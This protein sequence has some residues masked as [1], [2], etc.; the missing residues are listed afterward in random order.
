[1]CGDWALAD[2]AD[3]GRPGPA[4]GRG[5]ARRRRRPGRLRVR[6]SDGRSSRR[7]RPPRTR[8]RRASDRTRPGGRRSPTRV[9]PP[10]AGRPAQARAALPRRAGAAALGRLRRRRDRR[11]ARTWPT[12]GSRPTRRPGWPPWKSCWPRRVRQI[13]AVGAMTRHRSN[14]R[15]PARARVFDGE[16]PLGDGV[17]AVFRR[18]DRHPHA[19]ALR[20]V[21]GRRR[22]GRRRGRRRSATA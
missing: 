9:A 17:D 5:P 20:A 10:A 16:P 2:R 14:P 7:N 22:R 21:V 8:L 15:R 12:S 13:G 11:H 19:A 1:M 3:P 6:R 18:A 4:G